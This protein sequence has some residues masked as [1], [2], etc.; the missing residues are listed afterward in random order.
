M[1][2]PLTGRKGSGSLETVGN[3]GLLGRVGH[4]EGFPPEDVVV[5]VVVVRTPPE[6]VGVVVGVVVVG[7]VVVDGGRVEVVVGPAEVVA[8]RH[9]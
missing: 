4:V 5:V 3:D 1:R 6:V 8:G 9:W 2:E 7:V